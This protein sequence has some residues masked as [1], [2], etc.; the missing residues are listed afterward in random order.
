[1]EHWNQYWHNTSGVHSFSE[2]EQKSGY[3]ESISKHWQNITKHWSDKA[4]V[5]DVGAGNGG[6]SL[7]ILNLKPLVRIT[8]CDAADVQP[9]QSVDINNPDYSNL[10]KISFF[11]KLK[12]EDLAFSTN[13][14][15]HVVSQF[16]LEYAELNASL[17]QIYRVLKLN[18]RCHAIMHH[19]DSFITANSLTGLKVFKYFLRTN[20]LIHL[21]KAFIKA[22]HVNLSTPD[23][24]EREKIYRALNNDLMLQFKSIQQQQKTELEQEWFNETARPLIPHIQ[25]WRATTQTVITNIEKSL[26][27]F[28]TRLKEQTSVA[29]DGAEMAALISVANKLGFEGSAKEI[30]IK[31]GCLGWGLSLHKT[32]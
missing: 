20:G 31:E 17:E 10:K 14:F 28:Q 23:A 19:Q 15:D 26:V 11:A 8:A 27:H 32:S 4:S 12:V 5:L 22:S 2:G 25:N 9:M 13:S 1:M 21:L 18:G 29:K 3:G 30:N 6:L 7:L 24:L 16:G